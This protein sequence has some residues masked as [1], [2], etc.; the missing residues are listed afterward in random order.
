M[1][2]KILLR[3]DIIND[4]FEKVSKPDGK[5]HIG[6]M[7]VPGAEAILPV[8]NE[9]SSLRDNNGFYYDYIID[10]NDTH[11]VDHIGTRDW[12]AH[13][14][15]GTFGAESHP[16]LDRSRVFYVQPKGTHLDEDSKGAFIGD[17]GKYKTELED[18]LL[19]IANTHGVKREDLQ[20][21]V[22]GLITSICAGITAKQSSALGFNTRLILDGCRNI[23][24]VK[25]DEATIKELIQA[26]VEVITSNDVK[27]ELNIDITRTIEIDRGMPA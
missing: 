10:A 3:V 8:V 23:E 4:F 2:I 17:D 6:T 16:D 26:G 22:V 14:V 1:S 25:S 11:P 21:D 18:K 19:Q 7:G 27:R 24:A 15:E 20:I 5:I 12:P 13:S 9:L